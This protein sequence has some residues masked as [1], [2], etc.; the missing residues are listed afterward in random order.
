MAVNDKIVLL[1]MARLR[2]H[3]QVKGQPALYLPIPV[4]GGLRAQ[5]PVV[6][7]RVEE[8]PGGYA[9]GFEDPVQ[10]EPLVMGNPVVLLAMDH[11]GRGL[12]AGGV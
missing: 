10:L 4:E 1:A 2:L 3:V 7:P 9:L 11:Q 5:D 12:V 8:L 6:L